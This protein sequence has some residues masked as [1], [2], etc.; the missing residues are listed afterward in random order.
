MNSF[1]LYLTDLKS[2]TML[3]MNEE[4]KK[5]EKFPVRKNNLIL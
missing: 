2:S 3:T 4:G 1:N 5:N